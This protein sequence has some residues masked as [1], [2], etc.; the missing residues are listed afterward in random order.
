[1]LE[2]T[3]DSHPKRATGV[4]HAALVGSCPGPH[5]QSA[6]TRAGSGIQ[7]KILGRFLVLNRRANAEKRP[8]ISRFWIIFLLQAH[9]YVLFEDESAHGERSSMFFE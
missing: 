8:T 4:R 7:W 5:V 3:P 1:M 9:V 2:G 6:P